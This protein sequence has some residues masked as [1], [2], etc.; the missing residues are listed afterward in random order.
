MTRAKLKKA[1]TAY[2][3]AAKKAEAARVERNRVL[4]EAVRAGELTQAEAARVTDL[5][6][7]RIAQLVAGSE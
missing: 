2:R 3:A 4:L 1:E 5:T 7:G 6:T